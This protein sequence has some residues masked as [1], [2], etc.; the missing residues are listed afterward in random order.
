MF[1]VFSKI[2]KFTGKGHWK[3]MIAAVCFFVLALPATAQL[4]VYALGSGTHVSGTN[5]GATTPAGSSGSFT[6]YGAT[7]GI[8]DMWF[9]GGPLSLGSDF[10]LTFQSSGNSTSY[11]NNLRDG[12]VGLRAAFKAPGAPLRPYVQAGFGAGTTN[13]G[14]YSSDSGSGAFAYQ[15][16]A[17]VDYAVARHL[18]LRAEY[19]A[20]QIV[21]SS[22]QLG[23]ANLH[24]QQFGAGVVARF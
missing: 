19:G 1:N 3:T 14:R 6:A 12:F 24:L 7:F 16:Q 23:S 8:Y 15:L 21:S 4:G 11:G 18:D 9:H 2:G 10:R 13:Y 17:G 22:S 5:I 20:G